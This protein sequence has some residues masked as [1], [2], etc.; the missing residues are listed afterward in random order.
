MQGYDISPGKTI[1]LFVLVSMCG[2]SQISNLNQVVWD[3]SILLKF[4]ETKLVHI[5]NLA[6]KKQRWFTHS[7]TRLRELVESNS[8]YSR[9]FS[10]GF[11]APSVI[12]L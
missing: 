2:C 12:R 11:L 4:F 6:I 7:M 5:Q 9:Q 3:L 1:L 8:I 10:P